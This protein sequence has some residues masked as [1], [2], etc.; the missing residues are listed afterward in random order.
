M[1]VRKSVGLNQSDSSHAPLT[2]VRFDRFSRGFSGEV[3]AH[4]GVRFGV[5]TRAM[6]YRRMNNTVRTAVTLASAVT[7]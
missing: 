1:R 2:T 3:P 5:Y 6:T 7:R 4:G